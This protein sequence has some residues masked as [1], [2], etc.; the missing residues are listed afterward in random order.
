VIGGSR[1]GGFGYSP[2][3]PIVVMPRFE[4]SASAGMAE[5]SIV[6]QATNAA[7]RK[8]EHFFIFIWTLL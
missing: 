2:G 4:S 3:V 8:N 7:R 1:A 5:S 6:E